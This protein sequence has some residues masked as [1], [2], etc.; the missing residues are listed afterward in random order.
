LSY[1]PGAVLLGRQINRRKEQFMTRLFEKIYGCEAAGTIG[2]A[3]GDVTEGYSW[4]EIEEKW[5]FVDRMLPQ[6]KVDRVRQSDTSLGPKFVYHAHHRPAG[7]TEDGMERHRLCTSAILKKGGRI[8]VWDLAKTWA[9]DVDPQKFGYLMGPQDQVIYYAIKAGIPPWEVGRY[10]TWPTL[11]GTSKMIQPIGMINA[12]NPDQA[13][14][15]ALDVARLKDVRGVPGN[16]AH[17][18]A[19]GIAA[20]V[21]EAL[22][23]DATVDS[24]IDVAVGQLTEVPRAEVDMGLEWAQKVKDWKEL[25]PLYEDKYRGKR[26]SNAVEI[27]SGGLACFYV[28]KGQPKEAILYATNLGRD[29]DCKAYI[30]GGLAGALR[31]I[32]EVPAEWVKL[33]EEVVVHTPYT[34]SNRTAREAAEGLY[35]VAL[36]EIERMRGVISLVEKQL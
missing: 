6:D 36:K 19:A 4:Q 35:S 22:K 24:I 1:Q 5:G 30:A 33:V 31:G 23:P 20:A 17:E 14:L 12:C 32:E 21:A 15:D 29:T 25:R 26:I 28:A 7:T 10:A 18:V 3:M 11:I 27:L 13:A 8:T 2:N 16:Y 9:E 34:V